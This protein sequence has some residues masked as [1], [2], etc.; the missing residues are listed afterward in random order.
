MLIKIPNTSDPVK[1]TDKNTK[2]TDVQNK[3][4]HTNGLMLRLRKSLQ[5]LK[6]NRG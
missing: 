1:D 4:P 2:T 3:I 6:K 5:R